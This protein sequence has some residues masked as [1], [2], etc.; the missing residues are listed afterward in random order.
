LEYGT[1]RDELGL[2]ILH[3]VWSRSTLTRKSPAP[4]D[5]DIFYYKQVDSA[6]S[7]PHT[8]DITV[9]QYDGRLHQS[10]IKNRE[11]RTPHAAAENKR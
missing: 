4:H 6:A 1:E 3:L 5:L 7:S 2:E 11:K 9:G 8:T 10:D